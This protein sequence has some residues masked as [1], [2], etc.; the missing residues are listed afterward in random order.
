MGPSERP[1]QPASRR[2][3]LRSLW[4]SDR[5][6]GVA[7]D[8][9]ARHGFGHRS[10]WPG[11]FLRDDRYLGG[12]LLTIGRALQGVGIGGEWSGS[13]LIAG[14]WTDPRRTALGEPI[15]RGGPD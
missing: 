3:D 7:G 12:V 13:V 4:R 2:C 14:E 5:S 6:L 10:D 8:N 9:A 11:A 15:W 1:A